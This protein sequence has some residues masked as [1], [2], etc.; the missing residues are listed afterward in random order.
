MGTEAGNQ[1]HNYE[2]GGGHQGPPKNTSRSVN[3]P[4]TVTVRMHSNA[5]YSV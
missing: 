5:L 3:V 2:G 1:F 4:V